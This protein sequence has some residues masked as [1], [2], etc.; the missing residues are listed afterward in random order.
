MKHVVLALIAIFVF[1]TP[2]ARAESWESE[3]YDY[4]KNTCHDP[5]MVSYF[6][7]NAIDS[8]VNKFKLAGSATRMAQSGEPM[9]LDAAR[10]YQSIEAKGLSPMLHQYL[11]TLGFYQALRECYPQSEAKR[12]A[13]AA[14][15]I[16]SDALGTDLA[17]ALTA[18]SSLT[19][20][21][22][23]GALLT[24]FGKWGHAMNMGLGA[25]ALA[26]AAP[27]IYAR[28]VQYHAQRIQQ[29]NDFLDKESALKESQ[30]LF[31]ESCFFSRAEPN[32]AKMQK[33]YTLSRAL[34]IE[35]LEKLIQENGSAMDSQE[36]AKYQDLLGAVREEKFNCSAAWLQSHPE[37][38]S[39]RQR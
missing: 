21:R 38:A 27:P 26:A 9:S 19:L 16:F 2:H 17:F 8:M 3:A 36:K 24:R 1:A 37:D 30:S 35:D 23:G 34:F 12:N 29:K 15:L 6:A 33:S 10:V 5:I 18:Y 20:S 31:E 7:K 32:D 11:Q 39:L 13:Y 4:V 14:A 22:F 28:V 25:F